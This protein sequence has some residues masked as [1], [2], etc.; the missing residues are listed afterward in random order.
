MKI[1]LILDKYI[2]DQK[3]D[4]TFEVG[5]TNMHVD[6]LL[7]FKDMEIPD[8]LKLLYQ[9][10]NG[11][12]LESEYFLDDLDD[13]AHFRLISCNNLF[14]TSKRL[15]LLPDKRFIRF[16]ENEE[17]A[18]YLLDMENLDPDGNPLILLN[19]PSY[20]FSIPLT[21]NFEVLLE[22]AC[23]GILGLIEEF[24]LKE[25]KR[26][27]EVPQKM[28]RKKKRILPILKEFFLTAKREFD[29][30]DT[31]HLSP[32]AKKNIQLSIATWFKGLKKL[33]SVF[34]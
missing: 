29:L 19:M 5:I 33:L 8:Y 34:N 16:A 1:I 22:A 32:K 18:L 27:P 21:N 26:I 3:V 2:E 20:K 24:G 7:F 9:Q 14:F 30:I 15:N 25:G 23:L 13:P 10:S 11:F 6:E 12:L 17:D 28:L 4:I 31:W